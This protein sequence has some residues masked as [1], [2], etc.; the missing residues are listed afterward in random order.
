M[1]FSF[2]INNIYSFAKLTKFA[3]IKKIQEDGKIKYEVKSE[4]NP[5]WS[6]GIYNT[7]EEAE[8]RLRQVEFFKH[9]K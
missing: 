1:Q 3:Y 8:D 5:D 9:N 6:G 7:K 2:L 4:S